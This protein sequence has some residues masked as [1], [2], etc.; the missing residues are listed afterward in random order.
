MRDHLGTGSVAHLRHQEADQEAEGV[1][2]RERVKIDDYVVIPA[3]HEGDTIAR[4]LIY[5]LVDLGF[6]PAQIIVLVNGAGHVD[7]KPDETAVKALE[8]NGEIRVWHQCYLLENLETALLTRYGIEPGR[9]HG[10][11]TAMF[12]ACLALRRERLSDT[13][14][15][16]FLDADLQNLNEVKP[17]ERLL[18][19]SH[20]FPDAQLIKLAS[21]NRDNAGIHAFLATLGRP[22]GA[23]GA[24]R[25]PLCGQVMV[26]WG[27][28]KR[29]RLAGGY[30]VEMAMAMDVIERSDGD[31][32]VFAEVE[33]GTPLIDKRNSDQVH[34]RM[35][36][37]IMETMN[38]VIRTGTPLHA[39]TDDQIVNVNG[40][41]R[42]PHLW[43]PV[44]QQGD[45]PN[46]LE[47]RYPDAIFP[48]IEELFA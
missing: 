13:A 44:V 39:L 28:L 27:Q 47:A 38:R 21:L 7:G 15:V 10:K 14:R 1:E 23:I 35:Y 4:T 34:T 31:P 16:F 41:E 24:L 25:W 12:S 26:R 45:G 40:I 46:V 22:Y 43:V 30:A 5:L 37:E 9:L 48:S 29:M 8:V 11:G 42:I 6:Q 32:S 2:G 33:I 17:I 18:V 19:G 36:Y 3:K 20:H